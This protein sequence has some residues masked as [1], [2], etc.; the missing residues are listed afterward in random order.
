MG[1][2]QLRCLQ[3]V[4]TPKSYW[5]LPQSL[6]SWA[7]LGMGCG[8]VGDGGY[9]CRTES[10]FPVTS[11]G[12]L[13]LSREQWQ[14]VLTFRDLLRSPLMNSLNLAKW[15]LFPFWVKKTPY[16]MLVS[17]SH[18]EIRDQDVDDR[19]QGAFQK[20]HRDL[21]HP[22]VPYVS[23]G[24]HRLCLFSDATSIMRI[25]IEDVLPGMLSLLLP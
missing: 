4:K 1:T 24:P 5:P 17:R 15:W 6:W 13:T 2:T 18:Q 8:C 10:D 12:V 16:L 25:F 22:W 14:T 23:A 20:E 7:P 9:C 11:A 21:L 19:W 3:I